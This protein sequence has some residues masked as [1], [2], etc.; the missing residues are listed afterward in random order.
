MTPSSSR[1]PWLVPLVMVAALLV[2]C[3]GCDERSPPSAPVPGM[4]VDAHAPEPS[5]DLQEDEPDTT[6]PLDE[7][8]DGGM[9]V[10]SLDGRALEVGPAIDQPSTTYLLPLAGRVDVANRYRSAVMVSVEF[11]QGSSGTCSGVLVSR[12]LVLTAGH[13]VCP[14]R[15]SSA[16]NDAQSLID[17]SECAERATVKTM[18]YK[19]GEGTTEGAATSGAYQHGTVRPH[20][21]LRV[22]LDAQGQVVSSQADLAL[23][24]LDEP[25]DEEFKPIPLADSDLRLKETVVIVGSG[26]DETARAYDGERRYSRNKVIEL[27]PSGGGRMRIEQPAGHHY[28]GDSGGP[29][30]RE[31]AEGV[32]L[33][34]ISSR[35][36]GEGEAITSTYSYRDWLRAEIQRPASAKPPSRP[37]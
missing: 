9:E 10:I 37:K 3:S 5:S 15:T 34:G 19:L 25:V 13:C 12:R 24:Q 22:L 6:A 33:V 4:P 14:R 16:P 31:S 27:L 1:C 29:C 21:Q 18:A 35:N 26:Y 30:L 23:I 32:T 8:W 28:R 11:A 2:S 17:S 36:L 20:P 7:A